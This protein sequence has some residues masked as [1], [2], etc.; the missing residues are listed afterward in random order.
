MNGWFISINET[1][2]PRKVAEIGILNFTRSSG[3]SRIKHVFF[4]LI[5]CASDQ[6]HQAVFFFKKGQAAKSHP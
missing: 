6:I 1:I 2:Q 5:S 4:Q 3:K